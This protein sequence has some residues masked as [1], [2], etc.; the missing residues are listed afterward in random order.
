MVSKEAFSVKLLSAILVMVLSG[1]ASLPDDRGLSSVQGLIHQRDSHLA[2]KA[3]GVGSHSEP[4]EQQVETLLA[5]PLTAERALA[6]ALLKNPK[7]RIAYAQMGLNQAD[8][9]EASRLSNPTLSL[10]LL[11]SNVNGDSSQLGYGLVQNFTDILFVRQR[12]RLAKADLTRVQT[13]VALGLQRLAADV[14]EAYFAAVGAAQIAQMRIVT[15]KAARASAELARRFHDAGNINA[16]ELAREQAAAEQAQ[17]ELETAQAEAEVSRINLNT[18]MGL[19]AFST[20][21]LDARLPLPVAKEPSVHAL[22]ELGLKQRLDLVAERLRLERSDGN[23]SLAKKLRWIPF[24]ALGIEGERDFDGST[25]FG[26]TLAFELPLFG[27]S[28]TGILR[29]EAWQEQASARVALLEGQVANAIAKSYARL[30]STRARVERHRS[31]L[32][33][34][35]EAIVARTQELQNYMIVGQFELL[36]AKQEEYNAYESYLAT[37]RDYWMARVE[38]SRAV[39]GALP[40]DADIG[41]LSESSIELPAPQDTTPHHRHGGH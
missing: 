14:N 24:V 7:V 20:W 5:E 15:T 25:S 26:P 35:R 19:P 33:P 13:D 1:C 23:L 38:L 2:A 11:R 32:I 3:V 12:S 16:L 8:W 27:K 17:L 10:S 31:G 39:G 21:S 40:S 41:A 18:I 28:G 37:L 34:Q 30:Q 36:L 4:L 6:V 29:A 9:L 22:V